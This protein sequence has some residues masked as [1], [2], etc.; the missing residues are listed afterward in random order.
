MSVPM[1]ERKDIS[2]KIK[3]SFTTLYGENLSQNKNC[4]LISLNGGANAPYKVA[5]KFKGLGI[6]ISFQHLDLPAIEVYIKESLLRKKE[7]SSLIFDQFS[8]ILFDKHQIKYS[9]TKDEGEFGLYL[10]PFNTDEKSLK[11]V[12]NIL[13]DLSDNFSKHA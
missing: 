10:V 7:R 2:D 1:S 8:S 6:G 11:I 13:K 5:T 12:F 3:N 9:G 4:N